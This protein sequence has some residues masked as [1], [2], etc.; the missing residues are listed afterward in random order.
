MGT[1]GNYLDTR[2]PFNSIPCNTLQ[3]ENKFLNTEH[4]FSNCF[5]QN[6]SS[7]K[8]FVYLPGSTEQADVVSYLLSPNPSLCSTNMEE[9]NQWT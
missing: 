7:K 1:D 4:W 5:T 6:P 3:E 9:S 8:H 2:E